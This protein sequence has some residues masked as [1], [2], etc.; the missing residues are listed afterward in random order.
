MF[1]LSCLLGN[2]YV[3]KAT[4][5]VVTQRNIETVSTVSLWYDYMSMSMPLKVTRICATSQKPESIHCHVL[6]L[7]FIV[8]NNRILVSSYFYVSSIRLVII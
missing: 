8:T 4:S 7:S 5:Y 6:Q 2:L 3:S 1:H